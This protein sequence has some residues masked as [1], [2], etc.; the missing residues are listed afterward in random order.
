MNCLKELITVTISGVLV[1][2]TVLGGLSH[3]EFRGLSGVLWKP[4]EIAS[5]ILCLHFWVRKGL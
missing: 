1:A 4:P 3:D 2:I 5:R